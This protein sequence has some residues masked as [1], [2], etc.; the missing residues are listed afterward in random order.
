M[1]QTAGFCPAS[2]SSP[3]SRRR[4]PAGCTQTCSSPRTYTGWNFQSSSCLREK[5]QDRSFVFTI[6]TDF[7]FPPKLFAIDL[8]TICSNPIMRNQINIASFFPLDFGVFV[9]LQPLIRFTSFL[10]TC[11]IKIANGSWIVNTSRRKKTTNCHTNREEL[12]YAGLLGHLITAN[13]KTTG[14]GMFHMT[15]LSLISLYTY[16]SYDTYRYHH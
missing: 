16:I 9:H 8:S 11:K 4:S 13:M 2:Q 14:I 1:F 15:S 7:H 12:Q 6:N 10:Y 5:T 3:R